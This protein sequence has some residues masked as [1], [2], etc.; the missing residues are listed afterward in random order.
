MNPIQILP[1]LV[2][3]FTQNLE[4]QSTFSY[5]L[6]SPNHSIE[7]DEELQEISGIALSQ[8]E[9]FF[10]AIQDETGKVYV[11]EEES[12]DVE[13]EIDFWKDGDYEDL[14]LVGNELFVLKSSGTLYQIQHLG[15]KNQNVIKHNTALEKRHNTEGLCYDAFHHQLF[16]ACKNPESDSIQNRNIYAFQ[17]EENRLKEAASI[18]IG[19]AQLQAFIQQTP[20]LEKLEK[21]KE[22]FMQTNFR[23]SPSAIAIHPK[24][25][26]VYLLSAV[27]NWLL[28]LTKQGDVKQL[29]KLSKKV[30]YHPEGLAFSRSGTLYI[31]NEGKKDRPA[32]IH[33]FD[34]ED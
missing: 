19:Q 5:D 7:L 21:A 10:Y 8:D 14:E 24:T 27:G 4:V 23:F 34:M 15:Q 11:I 30:H 2:F 1:F 25:N 31:S 29:K 18:T 6:K 33:R 26:E 17:L 9:D 16:I 22:F 12:G 28:V 3:S 20:K 32:V 13:A